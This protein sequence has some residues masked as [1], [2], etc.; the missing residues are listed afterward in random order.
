MAM[1]MIREMEYFSI[2]LRELGVFSWK[3]RELQGDFTEDFQYIKGAYK[4]DR[5]KSFYQVLY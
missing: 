4:G 2:K 3:E 5:M 1:K